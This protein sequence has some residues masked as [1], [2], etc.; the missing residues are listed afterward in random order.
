MISNTLEVNGERLWQTLEVS[1][2]I[3]KYRETGLRRLALTAEDK[4]MR[5]IF[6]DWCKEAGCTI[7]V[8]HL[9]NIFATRPGTDN[10][11]SAV[12]C[13]SHLDTQANGG[14]YDGILGVLTGLE[15]VRTLND[16]NIETKRPIEV[17][18]W[19]NE[20]GARFTPPM[21]A[22]MAF[23]GH[24]SAESVLETQD[25][26]GITF[27]EALKQIGYAG[28][29]AAANRDYDS[30]FELHIEQGPILDETNE[31]VGIVTGGYHSRGMKLD[32]RGETAHAG[33]TAMNQRH[34]ALVGAGLVIAAINDIGWK[35]HPENGKSTATQIIC[36][37]NLAGIV[38]EYCRLSVDFR[39]PDE[40]GCEAMYADVQDAIAK[41]AERAM[42]EIEVVETWTF[43][44]SIFDEDC[45]NLL[46]ETA[47]SMGQNH[48]DIMSQAGHDAYAMA[49]TTPVAM[50][51]TPCEGG[52]SHNTG[53]DIDLDRTLPGVNVFLN[54]IV[55]RANR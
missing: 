10:S 31:D 28:D 30:Y 38:P 54:T 21:G 41:A 9:G 4:Q 33:P 22:A 27:G 29:K 19:T 18:V 16:R 44:D 6:V 37:P 3:G 26:D 55:T 8:D 36:E 48:V 1:G 39:H 50:I 7:E 23:V 14:K 13:G 49:H 43:G 24:I 15:I 52:V 2:E 42:V 12:S 47:D 20:E 51:F 53:E 34:N 25:T 35:Y 17:I 46:K 32:I 5:D 40:N 11:L 45:I